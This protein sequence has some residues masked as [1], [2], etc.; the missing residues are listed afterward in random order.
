MHNFVLAFILVCVSFLVIACGGSNAKP[1]EVPEKVEVVEV[2][3]KEV[4]ITLGGV[5]FD[6]NSADL[7]PAARE[8]LIGFSGRLAGIKNEIL[9]EGHTDTSGT[10]EF[11]MALSQKRANS[12]AKILVDVL[13]VDPARITAK[14][15]GI[16]HPAFPNDTEENRIKNRRVE[17]I[18]LPLVPEDS[19]RTETAQQDTP[20]KKTVSETEQ[21]LSPA[22]Q[23]SG[24]VDETETPIK[25][26][27]EFIDDAAA[28]VQKDTDATAADIRENAEAAAEEFDETFE[29]W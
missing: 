26:E 9:V 22:E 3:E 15:Y 28:Q 19:P 6:K 21:S 25:K 10:P 1:V 8:A 13:G 20:G 29:E 4:I 23:A 17:I 18:L 12:V 11:N 7:K 5:L 14:G 2:V 16:E 27:A 24:T